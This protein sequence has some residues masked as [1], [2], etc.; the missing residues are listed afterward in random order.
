MNILFWGLTIS[1]FGK[2]FLGIGVLI[3]HAK[4]AQEKSIDW[5]VIRSIRIEF[6][7]TGIGLAMIIFGYLLEIYFF[8]S[9]NLLLC[10]GEACV[11]N[12]N[13]LLPR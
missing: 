1:L 6:V 10:L 7:I 3:A 9:A 11:N 8:H 13:T 4:I 2:V 12:I 5:R